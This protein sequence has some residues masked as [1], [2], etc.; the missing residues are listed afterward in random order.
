VL[1]R[2]AL[3]SDCER[4]SH[5]R[6]NG[7]DYLLCDSVGA[8]LGVAIHGRISDSDSVL[9]EHQITVTVAGIPARVVRQRTNSAST[10]AAT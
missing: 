7:D 10:G 6:D 3:A 9:I 2:R 1:R 4:V 8:P 5:R